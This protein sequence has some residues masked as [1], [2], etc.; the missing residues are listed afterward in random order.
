[1]NNRA[2]SKGIP[3]RIK[4]IK[5]LEKPIRRRYVKRVDP[6]FTRSMKIGIYL[7]LRSGLPLSRTAE[8]SNITISRLRRWI[9]LGKDERNALYHGFFMQTKRIEARNEKEALQIIRKVARGKYK[10]KETKIITGGKNGREVTKIVRE[11]APVWQASAWFL[12]RR[13]REYNNNVPQ[14]DNK[15]AED[16]ARELHK[17]M[18]QMDN[19]VPEEAEEAKEA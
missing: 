13:Y 19:S 18:K 7:L 5:P 15:T 14:E 16:T 8:L 3:K 11:K 4:K 2:G 12:E 9:K 10:I 17:A 6:L 1:M